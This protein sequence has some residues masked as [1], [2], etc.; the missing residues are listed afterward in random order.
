MQI[1]DRFANNILLLKCYLYNRDDSLLGPCQYC[2]KKCRCVIRLD[3]AC[4]CTAATSPVRIRLTT[5]GP[6]V[7]KQE[8][9]LA[10]TSKGRRMRMYQLAENSKRSLFECTTNFGIGCWR[11]SKKSSSERLNG[12]ACYCQANRYG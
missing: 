10:K 6:L 3:R 1:K 7:R 5:Q 9:I 12:I 2:S 8:T 4:V 11:Q